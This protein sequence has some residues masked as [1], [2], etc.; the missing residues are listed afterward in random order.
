MTTRGG[1]D[2]DQAS[3]K[4]QEKQTALAGVAHQH[5][6]LEAEFAARGGQT[7]AGKYTPQPPTF[8]RHGV[9]GE[10]PALRETATVAFAG[11]ELK[12]EI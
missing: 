5:T 2:A 9:S 7:K 8:L 6:V 1:A 12:P 3:A 10:Q 4:A 11:V